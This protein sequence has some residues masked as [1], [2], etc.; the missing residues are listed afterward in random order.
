MVRNDSPCGSTIG[1]ILASNTSVESVDVGIPQLSMHSI[2]EMCGVNDVEYYIDF[3]VVC[4]LS[5]FFVGLVQLSMLLLFSY[6][7]C[8]VSSLIIEIFLR[9]WTKN[10]LKMEVECEDK[11]FTHF[12]MCGPSI[13]P[14]HTLCDVFV[15]LAH[16][17]S[18]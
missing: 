9:L 16:A 7:Y 14:D 1:P 13:Y 8:R 11:M 15:Y 17:L 18:S 4:I 2:R 5:L 6:L 3:F 12:L 10:K